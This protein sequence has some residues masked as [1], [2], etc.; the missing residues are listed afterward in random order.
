MFRIPDFLKMSNLAN[1][2][3]KYYLTAQR[4]SYEKKNFRQI[5]IFSF[6]RFINE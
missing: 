1:H 4:L 3:N 2:L 6:Y 5:S